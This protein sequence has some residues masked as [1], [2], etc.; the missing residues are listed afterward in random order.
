MPPHCRTRRTNGRSRPGSRRIAGCRAPSS[1]RR[2]MSRRRC[3]EIDKRAADSR[4]RQIIM[5]P[6]PVEPLGRKRYWPIYEAAS[7]AG[8]PI[9]FHPGARRRRSSVDRRRLAD[10][11]HAGSLHVWWSDAEH[12]RQHGVRRRVRAVPRPEDRLGRERICLGAESL[13]AHGQAFRAHAGRGA[14]PEEQAV[15]VCPAQS[16]VHHA[17]D[18]RDGKS[19]P[20]ARH[21]GL[22]RLGPAACSRATIR[23]GISTTRAMPSACT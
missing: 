19:G 20:P 9:A 4:F 18:G 1:S 5:S 7:R 14:A 16:L 23:T 12:R 11:L 6:K 21:H 8:L 3:S 10:L 13:L 17:A 2:R 22:D 15:G